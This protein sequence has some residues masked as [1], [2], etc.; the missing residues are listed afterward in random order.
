MTNTEIA[1]TRQHARSAILRE[2]SKDKWSPSVISLLVNGVE[3]PKSFKIYEIDQLLNMVSE[4]CMIRKDLI[5]SKSRLREI[6]LARN[7][8][9]LYL[10]DVSHLTYGMIGD[11]FDKNHTSVLYGCKRCSIDIETNFCGIRDK[12]ELLLNKM[13]ED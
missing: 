7:I 2:L 11:I 6:V 10:R 9:F 4:I 13:K 3:E 1:R 8:C 5:M 12:Y